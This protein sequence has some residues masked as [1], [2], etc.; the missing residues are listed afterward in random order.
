VRA[1]VIAFAKV[2]EA[3]LAANDGKGGWHHETTGYLSRRLYQELEEL[4]R[5][6]V[7]YEQAS[8]KWPRDLELVKRRREELVEECADVANFA[9][10][11]ADVAGGL[12]N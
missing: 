9:M 8:G 7:S 5:A 12:E 4:S 2:M 3:K 10:M 11:I 6:R 1:E